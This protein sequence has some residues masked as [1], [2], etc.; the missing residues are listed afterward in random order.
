MAWQSS[1]WLPQVAPCPALGPR[2]KQC[3]GA[4][5]RHRRCVTRPESTDW[6]AVSQHVLPAI[7]QLSVRVEDAW[8]RWGSTAPPGLA[9]TQAPPPSERFRLVEGGVDETRIRI[10]NVFYTSSLFRKCHLEVAAGAKGLS[11]LH[12]V[13]FPWAA[14]DLPLFSLDMVAFGVRLCVCVRRHCDFSTQPVR[15]MCSLA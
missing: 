15:G 2:Q 5:H 14:H 13:M 10:Q 8:L 4:H 11:V 12:C 9:L 1:A 6:A 7:L 3:R